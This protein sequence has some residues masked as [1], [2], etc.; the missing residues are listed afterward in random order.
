[1]IYESFVYHIIYQ[2][3]WIHSLHLPIKI[4]SDKS[5]RK[6]LRGC[7]R[8]VTIKIILCLIFMRIL[9]GYKLVYWLWYTS[10]IFI[11]WARLSWPLDLI[12]ELKLNPLNSWYNQYSH[13][14]V[15]VHTFDFLL[16]G[17]KNLLIVKN[18]IRNNSI[19]IFD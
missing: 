14:S 3:P 16:L 18:D 4:I 11:A 8:P 19:N 12:D 9:N 1:M 10:D 17:F 7:V 2:F 13:S 15:H 6:N 5:W